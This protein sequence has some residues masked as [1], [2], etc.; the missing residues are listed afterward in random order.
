MRIVFFVAESKY[1][2]IVVGVLKLCEE[3]CASPKL[4]LDT[5]VGL[6]EQASLM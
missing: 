4:V 6:Q 3:A 2:R 1:E 5:R